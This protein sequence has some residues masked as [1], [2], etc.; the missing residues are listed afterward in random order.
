MKKSGFSASEARKRVKKKTVS[1]ENYERKKIEIIMG[2]I[3]KL[4]I[5]YV[6][7]GFN[8]MFYKLPW[9]IS[10]GYIIEGGTEAIT[11]NRVIKRLFKLGYAIE[12]LSIDSINIS[13]RKEESV[14]VDGKHFADESDLLM[15]TDSREIHKKGKRKY[16]IIKD[17]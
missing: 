3:E 4:I 1:A 17:A 7:A 6:D 2:E 8:S 14:I 5:G 11:L 10:P 15:I 13:W 16:K 9:M 12:R